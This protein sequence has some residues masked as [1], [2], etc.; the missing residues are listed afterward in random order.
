MLSRAASDDRSSGKGAAES[1]RKINH[2]CLLFYCRAVGSVLFSV[3]KEFFITKLTGIQRY[4]CC[5][6]VV[7][8]I[9]ETS[10][11]LIGPSQL[12]SERIGSL[13]ALNDLED[14]N[15]PFSPWRPPVSDSRTYR[16]DCNLGRG[17]QVAGTALLPPLFATNVGNKEICSPKRDIQQ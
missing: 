9:E 6:R 16:T 5:R 11:R 17:T 15:T 14:E 8:G 1:D 10:A 3:S 7:Q 2:S 4:S 13:D 12:G